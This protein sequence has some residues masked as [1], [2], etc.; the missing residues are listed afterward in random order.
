MSVPYEGDYRN[1]SYLMKV[2]TG[3]RRTL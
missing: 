2:I 3:T 1:A